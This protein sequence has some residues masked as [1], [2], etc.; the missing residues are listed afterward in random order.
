VKQTLPKPKKVVLAYSGG[1]DTSI[2]IPWLRENYDCEV[3]AMIGDVGQQEDLEAAKREGTIRQ[4]E[5]DARLQREWE[6]QQRSDVVR[7]AYYKY[8]CAKFARSHGYGSNA[9]VDTAYANWTALEGDML[10]AYRPSQ[11][12]SYASAKTKL[13]TRRHEHE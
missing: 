4:R 8:K 10:A 6:A 12:L 9:Q 3:I 5:T 11:S 1:L 2:I 7:S 13:E